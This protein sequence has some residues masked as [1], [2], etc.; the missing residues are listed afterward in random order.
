MKVLFKSG[1]LEILD[2]IL[3]T[4]ELISFSDKST[5]IVLS[6]ESLLLVSKKLLLL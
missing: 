4:L 2:I 6:L 3:V 5:V 1:L